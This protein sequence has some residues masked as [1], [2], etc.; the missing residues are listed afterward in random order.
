M[1]K[2]EIDCL[3]IGAGP[4]GLTL[5]CQLRQ[6][7][8]SCRII[9]KVESP[10][11]RTK[12]AGIWSRTLE[13][14]AQMGLGDKFI[15]QGLQCYGASIFADGKRIAHLHLEGI[16]SFYNFILLIPQH[17]TEGILREHLQRLDTEV[18]YGKELSLLREERESVV[19]VLKSGEEIEAKWVVGCDG[20]HSRVRHALG[21]EF[22]GHKLDT[23]WIVSDLQ[24]RG[25]PLEEEVQVYLHEEGP[26]AFF[27]LGK[28]FYR[29]VA[30]TGP[31]KDSAQEGKAKAEAERLIK[32]RLPQEVEIEEI[33]RAGFFSIHER[34]VQQYKSGR[35]FLAGDAAHV[36]SPLGGQGMNTGIHDVNNLAWKLAM[37]IRRGLLP[38]L[39][40]T[41]HEERFPVGEWVVKAT[42]RG[43]TAI[44]SRQPLVAALRKQAARLLA[45]LPPVQSRIRNTLAETEIHYRE[46]SLSKEPEEPAT[47]WKFGKGITAG[48]RAPD[49]A[50]GE[51][52]R[53]LYDYLTG[54][55]FHLLLFT[56]DEDSSRAVM[57]GLCSTLRKEFVDL[58]QVLIVDTKPPATAIAEAVHILDSTADLHHKYAATRPSAYLL[59]P[60]TYVA[61]RSQPIS[62]VELLSYMR[63]L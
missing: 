55:R 8:V 49:G 19:A 50:V 29:L 60:D 20:A 12:A 26:T 16:E 45:N 22:V 25:L 53:R 57:E 30:E 52:G 33:K 5:A 35:V 28:R 47:G 27:P 3:V 43:M 46:S 17:E 13:F 37:V 11:I 40:E 7:G 59:R 63:A 2:K 56:S 6:Y 38:S 58:V 21:L 39:L 61:C 15:D 32:A 62:E 41:Y 18:E 23:Q 51:E 24:L 54:C 1:R 14:L 48:E 31:L 36:H 34:Q 4:V 44:T 42:S 9:D 10:V